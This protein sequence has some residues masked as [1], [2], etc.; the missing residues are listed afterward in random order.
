MGTATNGKSG[1]QFK[2]VQITDTTKSGRL[3]DK[4]TTSLESVREQVDTILSLVCSVD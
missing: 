3:V 1:C 2:V 4:Q